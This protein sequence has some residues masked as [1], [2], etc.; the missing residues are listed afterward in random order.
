MKGQGL[1]INTIVLAVL[2]LLVLVILAAIFVPGFR[3]LLVGIL[4]PAPGNVDQ[5]RMTC[6]NQW[7]PALD[8]QVGN[9]T[10]VKNFDWCKRT[11]Q[12]YKP[13]DCPT[14]ERC[15]PQGESST[16]DEST[17]KFSPSFPEQVAVACSFHMKNGTYCNPSDWIQCCTNPSLTTCGCS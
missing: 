1:P 14:L 10:E 12:L 16:C 5:F 2:A 8:Y 3:S 11:F 17:Q 7:C 6:E 4:M 15:Y 9:I 13:S